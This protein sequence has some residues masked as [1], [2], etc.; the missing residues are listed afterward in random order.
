M[1]L[2]FTKAIH[3]VD[4]MLT[5]IGHKQNLVSNNVANA[6]TP[7][8]TAK[9][10]SF[11][12][13]LFAA[14]SPFETRLSQKMGSKYSV[15]EAGEIDSG[16]PVQLQK[17]MIEMQKNLMLYSMTTRRASTIFNGLRTASQIGR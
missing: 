15:G 2:D 13:M 3:P 12:D 10:A 4:N 16:S 9:T 5:A 8:Y 1:G 7:G 14:N 6:H 11:S 17:E